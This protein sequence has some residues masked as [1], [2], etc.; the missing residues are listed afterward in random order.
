MKQENKSDIPFM[1]NPSDP[2]QKR[3]SKSNPIDPNQKEMKG[4]ISPN[5]SRQDQVRSAM[6]GGGGGGGGVGGGI[7][8]NMGG[9]L[10]TQ[11]LNSFLGAGN[12]YIQP[13]FPI[14]SAAPISNYMQIPVMI[15][16]TNQARGLGYVDASGGNI[17]DQYAN[18]NGNMNG[19]NGINGINM[20]G[21]NGM[22]ES[23]F[24]GGSPNIQKIY[25]NGIFVQA[26]INPSSPN[27]NI[28]ANLNMGMGAFGG[29]SS[30]VAGGIASSYLGLF[31]E[32]ENKIMNVIKSQNKILQ[33]MK[34]D[35]DKTHESLGRIKLE[36]NNLKESLK[37]INFSSL[38]NFEQ[39]P[40][41]NDNFDIFP[42]VM[43][44]V[45]SDLLIKY[46]FNKSDDNFNYEIILDSNFPKILYKE[47]YFK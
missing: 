23:F 8:A 17:N 12:M 27:P 15:A 25:E 39:R 34:E 20:N 31:Q 29:L 36:L 5:L 35:N 41:F 7:P 40:D 6:A 16:N 22:N 28:S 9:A 33:S 24:N 47:R 46:V 38:P 1:L 37:T 19:V 26:G 45:T 2:K 3:S 32:F 4:A 11:F 14:P 13:N 44:E 10:N 42:N 43:S 21:M 30:Q 18:A